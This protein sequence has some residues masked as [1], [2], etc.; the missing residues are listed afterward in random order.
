[1]AA[2]SS[3]PSHRNEKGSEIVK[4]T[5]SLKVHFKVNKNQLT[6]T[7]KRILCLKILNSFFNYLGA[8]LGLLKTY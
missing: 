8:N 5:R 4:T 2:A 3:L 7:L 1:M 6:L